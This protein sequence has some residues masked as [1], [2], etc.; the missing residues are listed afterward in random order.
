[1]RVPNLVYGYDK[2]IGDYFNLTINPDEAKI[3]NEIFTLYTTEGYGTAKIAGI[4][5]ERNIKTKRG[6]DW[7]QN[8]IT[9]I[10]SN[11]IY[12]GKIINGK[13]EIQD[14]LTSKRRKKNEDEWFVTERP[15]LSI[16]S[17]E[18]FERAQKTLESRKNAFTHNHERQSNKHLFSTL[19]KCK[20][21]GYS[22]RR[23]SY[24][25]SYRWVCSARNSKGKNACPNNV[26][27]DEQVLIENLQE[28]FIRSLKNR[29]TMVKN[30][31]S[32]FN[33]LYHE[34]DE[35]H[36]RFTE[37]EEKRSALEKQRQKYMD[38]Y[39]DELIS[40]EELNTKLKS[41]NSELERIKNELTVTEYNLSR[42]EML[43]TLLDRT[44][45]NME[46]VTDLSNVTN[47]Q[48]KKI[49]D[50]IEVDKDGNIDIFLKTL[51]EIGLEKVFLISD[52]HT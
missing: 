25:D 23:S 31:V 13:E 40:R 26:I 14:F 38:M 16:V 19:I 48:L 43:D 33:T 6:N 4:L 20:E 41:I 21:C 28:Y 44:F 3:V 30:I 39:V 12:T 24:K 18:T 49:I 2:T 11:N 22:F 10:L 50:R 17:D 51:D 45:A 35:N 7:T 32:R 34:S 42:S 37:L 46:S 47:A 27:I 5:N 8:S 1:G 15:E 36:E 52:N 29:D 9:R